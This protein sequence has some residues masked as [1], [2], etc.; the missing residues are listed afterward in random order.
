MMDRGLII[1]LCRNALPLSRKCLPTL[2]AQTVP[3]DVLVIDNASTDGTGKYMAAQQSRHDNV[4]RMTWR[5]V[6]SVARC[7][8]E[9]LFWAW[10]RGHSEALVVNS[11]TELLPETYGALKAAMATRER[12]GVMTGVG[13]PRPPKMYE[14]EPQH[15]AHPHYSCYMM[16]QWAHRLIPFDQR[17]EGAYLEDTDSH[18]RLFRAG[19]YAGSIN[20]E[21]LHHF[22]GTMKTADQ[23]ELDRINRHYLANKA[24]FYQEYGCVPGTKKYEALFNGQY[25]GP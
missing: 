25:V 2:L 8:N 15:M 24:R 22:S 14:G 11:D 23:A 20:L 1:L 9:G 10:E 16:A 13:V 5:N 17:Y 3:V 7:W 19:I 18:V 4:Y 21:F 6:E 12:C